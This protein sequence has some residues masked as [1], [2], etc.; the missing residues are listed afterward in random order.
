MSGDVEYHVTEVE[1]K[2]YVREK[3]DMDSVQSTLENMATELT[4]AHDVF[5]DI[6]RTEHCTIKRDES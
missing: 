4:D 6:S 1:C 3:T 2:V 5:V